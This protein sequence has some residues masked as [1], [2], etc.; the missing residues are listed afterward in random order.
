M[1]GP[2][3]RPG[4]GTAGA[5]QPRPA[6]AGGSGRPRR[7]S[8]P[9]SGPPHM[10]MM[11]PTAKPVRASS[12]RSGGCSASCARSGRMILVVVLLG[13]ISVLFAILGPKLLGEA[14]NVIFAGVVGQ[15]IPAG[16]TG[17]AGRSTPLNAAGETNQA[18]HAREHAR[19]RRPARAS[20]SR[21]SPGSCRRGRRLR[22]QLAVQLGPGLH[23][24]RRHP[25]DRVPAPRAGRREAR[26]AAARLL[27]PRVARRHPVAASPTTSTTSARRSSRA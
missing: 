27:R 14:T 23:H 19:R 17:P 12:A 9:G 25:A 24:G 2:T 18:E 8:G 13:V 7:G 21:C 26:P 20:T 6:P 10:A 1:S 22:V 16:V 15:Q 11:M 4:A 5:G 3:Q